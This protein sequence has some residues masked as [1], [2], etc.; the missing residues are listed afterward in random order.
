MKSKLMHSLFWRIFLSL[1]LGS[2]VLMIGSSLLIAVIAE[3]EV[4]VQ[5]LDRVGTLLRGNAHT[6]LQFYERVD[7]REFAAAVGAVERDYGLVIY[8]IDDA[9][10]ELLGRSLPHALRRFERELA[11]EKKRSRSAVRCA[12]DR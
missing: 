3:R 1:W 7:D 2:T 9:G 11:A 12:A 6:L 4:P 8:F 5:V 10:H